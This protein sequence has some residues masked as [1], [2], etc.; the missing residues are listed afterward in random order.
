MKMRILG[1][2][3]GH[4]ASACLVE[5]GK[6]VSA[7]QEERL[8]RIKNIMCFPSKSINAILKSRGI[9]YSDVDF[10][11]MNSLHMPLKI[12]RE[13]LV[14]EYKGSD[15]TTM[16]LRRLVKGVV[17]KSFLKRSYLEYRRRNRVQEILNQGFPYENIIFVE[18]HLA[19]AAAVY[20]SSPWNVKE[21]VLVLTN[22]A[23]GDGLCATINIGENGCIKRIGEIT[24]DHSVGYI[25]S[26]LTFILGMVPEE[27]EY[28][29]MGM[30]PYASN[31]D[32][33]KF[34]SELFR[35]IEF[36]DSTEGITWLR[37]N[38]CPHTQFSY[39][40]FRR[41]TELKRFD[42]ICGGIQ[43]FIEE[44][45]VSWVKNCI[46][47]TGIHKVALGGGVFM[48]VKANKL[49][50]ELPEVESLFIFPS[51]GDESSAIGAA[52]KVYAQEMSKKGY[53]INI[54]PL[55]DIYFGP[56]FKDEDIEE[57]LKGNGTNYERKDDIE[58]EVAILLS[59]GEIVARFKGRMEF[60]A[61]GLGNRSILAD[62]IDNSVIKKINNMIKNRDFWMP[63][64]PSILKDRES[65]YVVNPKNIKAPYMIMC[66]DSSDKIDD[67][68]AASHP[69][70]NTIRPQIV[71]KDGESCFYHLIK[72]FEKITGR[73]A[74]LNTS[75]N[76]HGYPIVCSPEDALEVFEKSA[77][78]YLAMGN[79][80]VWK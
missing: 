74:I 1:I 17:K 24:V 72:E 44:F 29:V 69:Y 7:I 25:Y 42:G 19:H 15:S 31:G 33:Q 35:L 32:T 47:K 59:Q 14:E 18:H 55:K 53:E 26:M 68:R 50:S 61:R 62:P 41:L 4:N 57:H 5:D 10:I 12:N 36:D 23:G 3:D 46:N 2:H 45:L 79:F 65:D 13:R 43:K 77:L 70:D 48:N 38:G 66:F 52:Y 39:S 30:A 49:I 54:S 37:K 80:L 40:Y 51:C 28:K 78:K 73:G 8:S 58:R 11:A 71:E 76:L 27:H 56:E 16:G 22:D 20:Y 63:F 67:M 60:G 6:I 9:S 75:F 64:A 34:Y 21:K